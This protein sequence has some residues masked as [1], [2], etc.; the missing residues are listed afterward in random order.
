MWDGPP[1]QASRP[2]DAQRS[3]LVLAEGAATLLVEDR[4]SANARGVQPYATI[5][6]F[7][8][9]SEG[10][11][12]RAVEETGEAA[13]RAMSIAICQAG[14][15][16]HDIDYICAHGNSMLNYD[17]AET[18]A[19]KRAFG[20]HAANVPVSSIKSMCGHALAAAG[21]M[22]VLTA[23]LVLRDGIAPPTINYQYPDPTCDLDYIP[24]V[25]RRIR[26]RNIL[27][28]SHSIGGTH[29]AIVLGAPG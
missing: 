16:P 8:S 6:G 23:C 28:H 27:V 7:A 4:T 21:A 22:Q 17:A 11:E 10:G 9:T 15:T 14:L 19:I 20:G 24:N 18:A 1:E 13:A 26:A 2:F 12:L 29:M 3:G 5:L 25:S